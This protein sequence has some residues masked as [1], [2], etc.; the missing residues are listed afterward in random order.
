MPTALSIQEPLSATEMWFLAI[1]ILEDKCSLSLL[2]L[3]LS[4]RGRSIRMIGFTDFTS[5]SILHGCCKF[6]RGKP[7][8]LYD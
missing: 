3:R 5:Q 6:R 1:Y 4:K 8:P 7:H 2:H